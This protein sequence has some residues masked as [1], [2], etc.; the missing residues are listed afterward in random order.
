MVQVSVRLPEEKVMLARE[1]FR[2]PNFSRWL[3]ESVTMMLD[4]PAS[5]E[6]EIALLENRVMQ[7]RTR[8]PEARIDWELRNAAFARRRERNEMLAAG[9]SEAEIS[10]KLERMMTMARQRVRA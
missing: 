10:A 7:L 9:A 2:R 4:D 6:A 8:L 1:R 3:E 5:I